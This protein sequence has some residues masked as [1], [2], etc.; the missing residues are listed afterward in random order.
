MF[1]GGTVTSSGRVGRRT[2]I[3]EA[4]IEIHGEEHSKNL[5]GQSSEVR[6]QRNAQATAGTSIWWELERFNLRGACQK[7][8]LKGSG[9]PN[10]ILVL[11]CRPR[12]VTNGV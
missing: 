3:R 1:A 10:Q 9:E 11:L 5:R 7:E 8:I 2:E 12:E 4:F 6:K